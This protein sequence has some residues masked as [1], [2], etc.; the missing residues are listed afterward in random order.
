[1]VDKSHFLFFPRWF[2]FFFVKFL[3][4]SML[5]TNYSTLFSPRNFGIFWTPAK[6]KNKP[7]KKNKPEQRLPRIS[8]QRNYNRHFFHLS[9]I[10]FN[11]H[12]KVTACWRKT[13]TLLAFSP[14]RHNSTL[15]SCRPSSSQPFR[16]HMDIL[17]DRIQQNVSL[18]VICLLT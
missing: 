11:F 5:L 9:W 14:H 8:G 10:K 15:N 4:F 1:M 13:K 17:C 12:P 16:S 3:L 18:F 6:P 7:K 2:P